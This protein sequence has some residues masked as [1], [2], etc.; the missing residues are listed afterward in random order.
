MLNLNELVCEMV[1]ELKDEENASLLPHFACTVKQES[2][3]EKIFNTV[4]C[5]WVINVR[6]GM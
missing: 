1:V 3:Y 2:K 6:S 4:G 5:S